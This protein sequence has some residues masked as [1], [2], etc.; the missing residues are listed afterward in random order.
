MNK[1]KIKSAARRFATLSITVVLCALFAPANSRAQNTALLLQQ[2][3]S[4]GGSITPDTGV[5]YFGSNSDVKITAIP[6]PGYQFVYWLGDVSDPRANSTIVS[7][8]A[9]KIIIAVFE[10][11]Q[12]DLPL[13]EEFVKSAP[14]GG[15]YAGAAD[16]TRTGYS[17]GGGGARK[18]G[19]S[20]SSPTPPP[21]E[22]PD[23]PV[24]DVP[25]PA[26]ALLLTLGAALTILKKPK[27]NKNR[28]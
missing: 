22:P 14:L 17:G 12:H 28:K 21:Y 7:L 13:L 9:P 19:S 25:E 24:P 2:T 23:F 26:S 18:R 16:Y 5:H 15:L 6:K 8:S 1:S 20:Y 10:R 3:P 4:E 11:F 27:R